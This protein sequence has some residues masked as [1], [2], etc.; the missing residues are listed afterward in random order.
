MTSR[1][2][3]DHTDVWLRD[4]GRQLDPA[5]GQNFDASRL[6]ASITAHLP[7][8][9]RPGRPLLTDSPGVWISDRVLT[10]VMAVRVRRTVGRLVVGITAEGSD[11]RV[12]R[13][14]LGLVARYHDILP[15]E[16]DLIRDV[17]TEVLTSLLGPDHAR[18]AAGAIDVRWGDL[19][20][21]A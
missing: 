17:V 21:G 2:D 13:I 10:Q 6:V 20:T 12:E 8:A 11:G 19:D 1:M 9:R 7:R 15:E 16:S 5:D 3:D 14:R 18:A 4:A